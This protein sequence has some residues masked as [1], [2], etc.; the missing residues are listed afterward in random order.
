ATP[1]ATYSASLQATGGVGTLTWSVATGTL[2]TGLSLSSSGAIAGDPTVSGAWAFTVQ[3]TDSSSAPSGPASAQAQLSLTVVTVVS[4][5]TTAL[6]AGSE[7]ITYLAGIDPSGGT[8]PYTW[9]LATGSLPPGLSMQPSSGLISGCPTSQ[10]NFSF[11]VT[12]RDSSPTP[13]TQSAPLTIAIGAPGPLAI[14][15]SSLLN[16][17]VGTLYNA[18]VARMG[19]TPPYTWSISAGALPAGVQFN[20]STG[21][22]SGTVTSTG[23]AYFTVMVT[24]SSSTPETQTQALSLTVDNPAEACASSGNNAVLS[25]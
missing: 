20:S 5:S 1:N 21:T 7:G 24:D 12:A 8:P 16:G 4:L 22:I 15:T 25:G 23:T 2:P 13:Q 3:V 17:T 19:G 9:S 14:T 18:K 10:G 11:T 6:P